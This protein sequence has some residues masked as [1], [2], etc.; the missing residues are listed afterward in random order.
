M[1]LESLNLTQ[2]GVLVLQQELIIDL[3]CKDI[4]QKDVPVSKMPYSG[5]QYSRMAD[6]RVKLNYARD[7]GPGQRPYTFSYKVLLTGNDHKPPSS[8]SLTTTKRE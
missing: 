5:S 8:Y 1:Y 7:G 6:L 4:A 3:L 2:C